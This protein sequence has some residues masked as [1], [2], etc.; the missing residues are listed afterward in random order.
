M[1]DPCPGASPDE[2]SLPAA[3]G[4]GL[5]GAETQANPTALRHE[6]AL[7]LQDLA[8]ALIH[9]SVEESIVSQ[10]APV[11]LARFLL[12]HPEP[13]AWIAA[14]PDLPHEPVALALIEEARRKLAVD[15]GAARDAAALAGALLDVTSEVTR[16]GLT[17][18]AALLEAYAAHVLGQVETAAEVLNAHC[19]KIP[20]CLPPEL[21]GD[22]NLLASSIRS[23]QNRLPEA[24]GHLQAALADY[25]P[26]SG[27]GRH[28]LV[29]IHTASLLSRLGDQD[30]AIEAAESAARLLTPGT[31]LTLYLAARH[32]LAGYLV[33]TGQHDRAL[34]ILAEIGPL[35]PRT[36]SSPYTLKYRWLCARIAA[37]TGDSRGAAGIYADIRDRLADRG[38]HRD[39]ALVAIDRARLFLEEPERFRTALEGIE[40]LLP[41]RASLET[42][43]LI[44]A[45]LR[46]LRSADAPSPAML[47]ALALLLYTSG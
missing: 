41:C 17:T 20:E 32:N 5:S 33:A 37:E 6:D 13:R 39:A 7:A 10:S 11:D 26:S 23:D 15:P 12:G 4:G 36:G 22:L 38:L 24:C 1:P 30:G 9:A 14:H 19:S 35:Y 8:A 3:W 27:R 2:P 45:H 46:G 25:G 42:R 44:R 28:A 16:Q 18:A 47:R 21:R 43:R 29:L 34:E 40:A 31:D